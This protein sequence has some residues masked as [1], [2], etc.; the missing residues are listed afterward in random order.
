MAKGQSSETPAEIARRLARGRAR[1]DSTSYV[2]RRLIEELR[3]FGE[4]CIDEPVPQKLLE[5]IRGA[6]RSNH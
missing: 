3:R 1:V 2:N 4:K 5:V 6:Q